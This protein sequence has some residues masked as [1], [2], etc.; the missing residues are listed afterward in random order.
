MVTKMLIIVTKI[1][2]SEKGFFFILD[3]PS[4]RVARIEIKV[5]TLFISVTDLT[6]HATHKHTKM[7]GKTRRDNVVKGLFLN[8]PVNSGPEKL[9]VLRFFFCPKYQIY[10]NSNFPQ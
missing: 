10:T 6:F 7:V 3:E 2:L 4:S 5:C 8:V 1:S 9:S